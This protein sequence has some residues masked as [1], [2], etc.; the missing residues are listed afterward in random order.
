MSYVAKYHGV[1]GDCGRVM[2]GG[3]LSATSSAFSH[4]EDA[5]AFLASSIEINA[6]AG[7]VVEG[8]V[9]ESKRRPEII[10]HCEGHPAQAIGGICFGCRQTVR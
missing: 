2:L 8:S 7:R 5:E 10:R 6:S 4:R 9:V 3:V 1:S